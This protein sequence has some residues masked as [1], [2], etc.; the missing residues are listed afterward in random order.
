MDPKLALER[1]RSSPFPPLRSPNL[2]VAP[3][4]RCRLPLAVLPHNPPGLHFSDWGDFMESGQ[5]ATRRLRSNDRSLLHAF[6]APLPVQCRWLE[7]GG[8][9]ARPPP[10]AT[11]SECAPSILPNRSGTYIK[12]SLPLEPLSLLSSH[13]DRIQSNPQQTMASDGIEMV[14]MYG[15]RRCWSH[16][17]SPSRRLSPSR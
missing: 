15:T 16:P 3:W 14:T 1:S 7:R 8:R 2:T 11:A 5:D 12:Q 9:A 13:V 10:I 6:A 4:P 17:S